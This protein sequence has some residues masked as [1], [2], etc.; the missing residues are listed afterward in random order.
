MQDAERSHQVHQEVSD[1]FRET[2]TAASRKVAKSHMRARA[3]YEQEKEAAMLQETEL[4]LALHEL[5]QTGSELCRCQME[6]AET[7]AAT[8]E[9]GR[10]LDR[11]QPVSVLAKGVRELL[12]KGPEDPGAD[13]HVRMFQQALRER[14]EHSLADVAPAV[15]LKAPSLRVG[16]AHTVEFH[17]KQMVREL[18]DMVAQSLA[19]FQAF[20]V[21]TTTAQLLWDKFCEG[22]RRKPCQ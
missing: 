12:Q 20:S 8:G 19:V 14:G 17:L 3:D 16:F 13:G 9:A 15:L 11:L 6:I 4:A 22:F 5:R 1:W 2:L 10:A 18:E 21:V 7:R